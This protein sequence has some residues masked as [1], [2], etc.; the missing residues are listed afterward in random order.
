MSGKTWAFI[1]LALFAGMMA[2][3][4]ALAA[5]LNQP[6]SDQDKQAFDQMLEPILRIYGFAKYTAT[7]IA[8]VVLLFAGIKYITSGGDP[9]KREDAKNMVMYVLIGLAVIW[10]APYAVNFVIGG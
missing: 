1:G 5:D 6:I 4:V 2:M 3:Q 9:K 8:V 7:V 10:A